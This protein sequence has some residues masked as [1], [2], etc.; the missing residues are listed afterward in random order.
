MNFIQIRAHCW[1][2][3]CHSTGCISIR[4]IPSQAR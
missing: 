2:S 3:M 4:S 1:K